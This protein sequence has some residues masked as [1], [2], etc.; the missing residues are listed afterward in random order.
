[1][2]KKI[3]VV[4]VLL[5]IVLISAL[6]VLNILYPS[7]VHKV[8]SIQDLTWKE[9]VPDIYYWN[10]EGSLY[11]I[12]ADGKKKKEIFKHENIENV[13]LLNSVK[14]ILVLT[15][16]SLILLDSQGENKKILFET[17]PNEEGSTIDPNIEI[18]SNDDKII[19]FVHGYSLQLYLL[20]ITSEQSQLVAQDL[21]D[22]VQARIESSY[23]FKDDSSFVWRIRI[24]DEKN[25]LPL[26]KIILTDARTLES[27]VIRE[28]ES[29]LI[30]GDSH[31]KANLSS[32]IDTQ[33]L[34]DTLRPANDTMSKIPDELPSPD[35]NRKLSVITSDKKILMNYISTLV[36]DSTK[37]MSWSTTHAGYGSIY[38]N[39]NWLPDSNH[40][41]FKNT[42]GIIHIIEVDSQKIA[43][44]V[45]DETLVWF[46]WFG[47]KSNTPE[48]VDW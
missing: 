35:G 17:N 3:F 5:V 26:N 41:I 30:A 15:D 29:E 27:K 18:N 44:L 31:R 8:S 7:S 9:E 42:N 22:G 40:I 20:E 33:L 12:S 45:E 16:K 19:F 6:F 13:R 37:L 1:M 4:I 46:K 2:R 39:F 43:N 11:M 21:L 48:P 32:V 34:S 10:N 25:K 24:I 28:Y 23:W 38:K 36:V 47:E 14:K